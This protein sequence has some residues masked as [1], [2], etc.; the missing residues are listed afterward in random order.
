MDVS[1]SKSFTE[2]HSYLK[3]HTK[4]S[5]VKIWATKPRKIIGP[6]LCG[7]YNNSNFAGSPVV[8][9]KEEL[10]SNWQRQ[11]GYEYDGVPELGGKKNNFTIRC[12]AVNYYQAGTYS[13]TSFSATL[14]VKVTIGAGLGEELRVQN[15]WVEPPLVINKSFKKSGFVQVVVEIRKENR[16]RAWKGPKLQDLRA[17]M[18]FSCVKTHFE[19]SPGV[20]ITAAGAAVDFTRAEEAVCLTSP[21]CYSKEVTCPEFF[22]TD[23]FSSTEMEWALCVPWFRRAVAASSKRCLVYSVGIRQVYAAE[24]LYGSLGCEVFAFDCTSTNLAKVLAPNVTFYPWCV[25]DA[26][27]ELQVGDGAVLNE[28]SSGIF[29]T[30]PEIMKELGHTD[31][32]LT[33]LKMDCE[34]CEWR[35][36]VEVAAAYP[37]MFGHIGMI[38]LELHWVRNPLRT[39][40]EE[41]ADQ[42]AV[43]KAMRSFFVQHFH[44]NPDPSEQRLTTY[45][46]SQKLKDAGLNSPFHEIAFVNRAVST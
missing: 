34:G 16:I 44:V 31:R 11:Y 28:Q 7:Y 22:K 1:S 30:L 3:I 26:T 40:D 25:G 18:M 21:N 36:L 32:E 14:F 12:V 5:N 42:A 38:F 37:K 23:N 46:L 27:L 41:I 24:A 9:E 6:W 15:G 4:N 35:A 10:V 17:Y 8:A 19:E 2:F 33:V 39:E 13:F 29:K 43:S 45:P 20:P